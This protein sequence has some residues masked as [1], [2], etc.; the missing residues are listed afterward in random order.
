MSGVITIVNGLERYPLRLSHQ[1]YI[2]LMAYHIGAI[3][4]GSRYHLGK[5]VSGPTAGPQDQ[6]RASAAGIADGFAEP[7]SELEPKIGAELL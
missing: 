2:N 7:K 4:P 1:A 6:R 3:P 5:N